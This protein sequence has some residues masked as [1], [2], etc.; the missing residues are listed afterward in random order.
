LKN[1]L[2]Q[3][4]KVKYAVNNLLKVPSRPFTTKWFYSEKILN[5]VLT[6]NHYQIS[7][8]KLDIKNPMLN[9]Q[10]ETSLKPFQILAT[11]VICDYSFLETT[12]CLRPSFPS[13]INFSINSCADESRSHMA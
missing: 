3:K 13:S 7:G 12:Q 2:K 10:G 9:I 4:R 11:D 8:Q 6:A 1:K 5:D